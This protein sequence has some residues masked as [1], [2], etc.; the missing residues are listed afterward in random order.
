MSRFLTAPTEHIPS[1]P[2]RPPKFGLYFRDLPTGRLAYHGFVT[3][4]AAASFLNLVLQ[5]TRPVWKSATEFVTPDELQVTCLH[6]EDIMEEEQT[7]TLPYPYPDLAN[8]I[9]GRTAQSYIPDPAPT[10]ASRAS[11]RTSA[12]R[13][14]RTGDA[15]HI[16][17]IASSVSLD[18]GKAR[19][20][21]RANSI[22]KPYAWDNPADIERITNLLKGAKK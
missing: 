13:A 1:S 20:I 4:V 9:A 6:L 3:K 15:T 7:I 19:R 14:T 22:P 10:R 8:R 12:P 18:A 11:T 16:S 21:L 2:Q 17:D 5:D